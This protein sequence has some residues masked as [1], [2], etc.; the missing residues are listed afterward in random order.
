MFTGLVT[1]IGSV[2]ELV[3]IEAEAD[4][5]VDLRGLTDQGST[6]RAAGVSRPL[7][8][9]DSIALSG[10]CCTLVEHGDGDQGRFRLSEE[11]LRCTWLGSVAPDVRLNLEAALCAGDPLGGHLVQG[12]VDGLGSISRPVD[13]VAGGELWVAVPQDLQKYCVAKGSITLDGVS[14]TIADQRDGQVMIALIP[15]TAE[16]TTLGGRTAGDPVHVEVDV[17]AK[18]VESMLEARG[19]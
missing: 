3:S 9:G 5:V 19:L 8:I 16:R 12:H 7:T 18:Y 14:L 11:T 2:V 13:P 6:P 10:V 1:A 4:L 15:H 17:L